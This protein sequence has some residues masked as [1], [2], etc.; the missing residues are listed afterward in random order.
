MK[1]E[2][3]MEYI[4]CLKKTI[5]KIESSETIDESWNK[6]KGAINQAEK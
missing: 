5:P 3:R 1:P 6:I 2:K 4:N